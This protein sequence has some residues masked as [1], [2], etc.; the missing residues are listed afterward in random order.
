MCKKSISKTKVRLAQKVT[1]DFWL[2]V[3]IIK[4][5]NKYDTQRGI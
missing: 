1:I 4:E 2:Y 5:Y 3:D